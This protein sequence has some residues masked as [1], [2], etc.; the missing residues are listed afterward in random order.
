MN[1]IYDENIYIKIFSSKESRDKKMKI[2]THE[3]IKKLDIKN[4]ECYSWLEE[5]LSFKQECFLPAKCSIKP[6]KDIFFTSMPCLIPSLDI[7]GLK[8]VSRIPTQDPALN[9]TIMLFKYSTGELL[10]IIDCNWITAMR[11]GAVATMSMLKSAKSDFQTLGC[12]GLGNTCVA[13]LDIL[14]PMLVSRTLTINLKKYKD[15]PK[16][17]MKRYQSFSNIEF[18]MIDDTKTLIKQSDVVLSC[19][20]STDQN[21]GE[22]EWFHPGITIIPVHTMGFQNCDLFFDKVIIDDYEHVKGFKYFNE[23]KNIVE[24]QELPKKKSIRENDQERII[25]YNVGIALHDVYFAYKIFKQLNN[26]EENIEINP[27]HQKYWI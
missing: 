6:Q 12:I 21:I 8:M 13:T 10:G 2:I 1:F 24:L 18:K 20:T 11:T 17:I 9:S 4:E 14:L 19:I 15:H 3:D 16:R 26:D 27:P 5:A 7:Y 22:N 23:F 25:A